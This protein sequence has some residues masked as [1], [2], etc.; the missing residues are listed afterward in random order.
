MNC[1]SYSSFCGSRTETISIVFIGEY[2]K[3]INETYKFLLDF[4]FP[5]CSVI[6][7][8]LHRTL[9][10]TQGAVNHPLIETIVS[11]E[12]V[13]WALNSF[14]P[15]KSPGTD[16]IFP[17]LL[18]RAQNHI[19]PILCKLFKASLKLKHI[20]YSWRGVIVQFLPKPGKSNYS[21]PEN[22][23]PIS[24]TSFL[25]KTLEKLVDQHI[26]DVLL[27]THKL[28]YKQH[29]YQPGKSTENALHNIVSSI[30]RAIADKEFALGYF[31][32]IG[33]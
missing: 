28:H 29:A 23:R 30:E 8:V 22:F 27:K 2:T 26:R 20:P 9:I 32:D 16:K 6:N 19:I 21:L 15:L 1:F 17:A 14:I 7:N 12:N 10:T 13:K 11:E 25:L 5:N 31:I 3:T 4:H 33:D 18:Q 24:L